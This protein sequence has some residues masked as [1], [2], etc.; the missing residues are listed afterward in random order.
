MDNNIIYK[1]N[2]LSLKF[3]FC[4]NILYDNNKKIEIIN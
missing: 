1:I 2:E 4:I 3:A